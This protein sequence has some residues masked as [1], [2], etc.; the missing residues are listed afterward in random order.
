MYK[1]CDRAGVISLIKG[2]HGGYGN[3]CRNNYDSAYNR[4]NDAKLLKKELHYVET[5]LKTHD[6]ECDRRSKDNCYDSYGDW[7][8]Y[9]NFDRCGYDGCGYDGCFGGWGRPFYGGGCDKPFYDG[10]CGKP[11]YGGGCGKPFYGGGCGKYDKYDKHDKYDKD[12][13]DDDWKCKKDKYDDDDKDYKKHDDKPCNSFCKPC[14]KPICNNPCKKICDCNN[15]KRSY[16][17]I[18][19]SH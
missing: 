17:K 16:D 10:G 9:H 7:N 12:W 1:M 14:Y 15:C 4:V 3:H 2:N 19:R 5:Y 6:E 13:K 11:F 18:Y 8:K